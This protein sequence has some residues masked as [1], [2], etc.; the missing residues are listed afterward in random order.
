VLPPGT[1]GYDEAL[2]NAYLGLIDQER[3]DGGMTMDISIGKI[4]YLRNRNSIN[5]NLSVSNILN[6]TDVRTGGY[7]QGR[8]QLEYPERFPSRYYYMQGINAF[9]NVSYRF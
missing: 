9:L 8:I 5:F 4:L 3:Y 6:N 1:N 2:Y 7:E